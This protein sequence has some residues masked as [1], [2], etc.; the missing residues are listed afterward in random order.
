MIEHGSTQDC[1]VRFGD[2]IGGVPNAHPLPPLTPDET[3]QHP[4]ER[5]GDYFSRPR[6]SV[7]SSLSSRLP[8]SDSRGRAQLSRRPEARSP[9]GAPPSPLP[10][11]TPLQHPGLLPRLLPSHVDGDGR[12]YEA[13]LKRGSCA[14]KQCPPVPPHV[15]R[16]VLSRGGAHLLLS[17]CTREARRGDFLLKWMGRCV[18]LQASLFSR[19][20]TGRGK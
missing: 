20:R 1:W 18:L 3:P 8:I 7:Y 19:V 10:P 16:E 15:W 5:G 4:N 6:T 14:C 2:G 11:P 17:R 12:Q 13:R 9:P